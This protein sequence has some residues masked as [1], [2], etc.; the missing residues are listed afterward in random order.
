MDSAERALDYA[1]DSYDIAKAQYDAVASGVDNALDDYATAMDNAYKS[2]QTALANLAA[3]REAAQNQLQ[4]Y[5][6][7]LNSTKA[8]SDNTT[9]QVSLRHLRADLASTKITAPVS[10]TI[11]AVYA[12]VGGG[13]SG[14]LFVIEDVNNLVV[15]TSVKEYDIA[16]V[17][18]GMAVTIKSDATDDDVFNGTIT[19]I[20]PTSTKNNL[21]ETQTASDALFATEVT[22]MS[23]NTGLKIGMSVRLNYIIA[24]QKNV[25]T[26]PY[27]A[28]YEN[29]E[30]QSC[31]LVASEQ[32]DGKYLLLELPV[33][34]GIG[35][36]LDIVISGEGVQEG[37]RIVNE[38]DDYLALVGKPVS[39]N[40]MQ[41][42]PQ[43]NSAPVM[44]GF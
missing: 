2:Y 34:T 13:G 25:L 19:S 24:E 41:T 30:G 9:S 6:N 22:V 5:L 20:A 37:L 44:G 17:K 27:D 40:E 33:E 39:I 3:A 35:N 11:T 12:K 7:A 16:T 1:E 23:E 32:S 28:V 31:V 38:P 36:D 29:N 26:V 10:G 21:G 42:A 4:S 8:S 43:N 18:P 14:L 15:E